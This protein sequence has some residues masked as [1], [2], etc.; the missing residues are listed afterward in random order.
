M[1]IDKALTLVEQEYMRVQDVAKY[2]GTSRMAVYEL[3]SRGRLETY[4]LFGRTLVKK[5]D[6]DDFVAQKTGRKKIKK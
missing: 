3:I 4:E 5:S 6:V 2:R 1:K